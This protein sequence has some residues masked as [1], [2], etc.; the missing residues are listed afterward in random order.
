MSTQV[1]S[2]VSGVAGCPIL[3]ERLAAAAG[4]L[5]GHLVEEAGGEVAVHSTAG[6]AAQKLFAQKNIAVAGDIN[7]AYADGETVSYG[8]YHAG[9]EVLGVVAAAADAI[10]DGAA[11]ESAGDGT[12]RVLASGAIVAYAMESVDNSGAATVARIKI[13]VA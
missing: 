9:Q 3:N 5:P 4:I 7:A 6:G 10:T 12:L 1:I 2:L 13:R 11:L 8:A